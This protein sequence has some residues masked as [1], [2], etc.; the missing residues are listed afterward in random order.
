MARATSASVM[1]A[2]TGG[3]GGG[4]LGTTRT[5]I[6]S[7]K[8]KE[9]MTV[10]DDDR[11]LGNIGLPGDESLLDNTNPSKQRRTHLMIP[12]Q[13]EDSGDGGAFY[14]NGTPRSKIPFKHVMERL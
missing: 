14:G 3:F 7:G 1:L 6:G 12:A 5:N 9:P 11:R 8:G 10:D 13:T 2:V 4:G